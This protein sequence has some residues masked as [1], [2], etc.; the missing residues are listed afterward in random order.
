MRGNNE[1]KKSNKYFFS[2]TKFLVTEI[3][4]SF[5]R[6]K[7]QHKERY[8]S[9]KRT[10]R[11]TVNPCLKY[12]KDRKKKKVTF[13]PSSSFPYFQYLLFRNTSGFFFQQKKDRS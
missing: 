2:Q 5:I 4:P 1:R 3:L 8:T 12:T 6:S 13:F 10:K 9:N 7:I 11:K